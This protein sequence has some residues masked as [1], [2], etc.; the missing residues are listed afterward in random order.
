MVCPVL[1]WPL[2]LEVEK[3]AHNLTEA[4]ELEQDLLDFTKQYGLTDRVV[5][6]E[7][8]TLLYRACYE[9]N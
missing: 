4:V 3:T 9:G 1:Q 6:D 2:L 7:P 8:P 5:R